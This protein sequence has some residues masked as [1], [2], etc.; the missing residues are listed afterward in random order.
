MFKTRATK[1]TTTSSNKKHKKRLSIRS[2]RRILKKATANEIEAHVDAPLPTEDFSHAEDVR[3]R[4]EVD[5]SLRR[6]LKKANEIEAHV[7]AP[8]LTEDFSH[9]EDVS[10]H[11]EVDQSVNDNTD[12][13]PC[14]DAVNSTIEDNAIDS[15]D[16]NSDS[17]DDEDYAEDENYNLEVEIEYSFINDGFLDYIRKNHSSLP[18]PDDEDLGLSK[19]YTA[20][21]T[22]KR[23][24]RYLAYV[25][26]SYPQMAPNRSMSYSTLFR[27]VIYHKEEKIHE[28]CK[29]MRAAHSYTPATICNIILDLMKGAR[30]SHYYSDEGQSDETAFARFSSVIAQRKKQWTRLLVQERAKAKRKNSFETLIK[31]GDIPADGLRGMQKTLAP[32]IPI[33][34][35]KVK[36]VVDKK[37]NKNNLLLLFFFIISDEYFDNF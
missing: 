20:S 26:T 18:P 3:C 37:V 17:D 25:L 24:A 35:A 10:C 13:H 5:Q 6:L 30:W 2:L 7:D 34:M 36:S 1:S 9:A 19:D 29:F 22:V 32:L 31:N 33:I 4:A 27:T 12:S 28:F 23:C 15:D 21:S 11:A 8:L 14:P 16:S